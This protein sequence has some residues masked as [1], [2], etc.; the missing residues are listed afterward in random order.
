ML[1]GWR[2]WISI[3]ELSI[4]Q[5]KAKVD[6]GARTSCLHAFYLNTYRERGVLMLH[7]KVHPL[8]AN[9][10]IVVECHAEAIDRRMVTDSGGHKERRYVIYT[11]ICLGGHTWPI[12]ITLTNRD[13][14]RYRMLLGRTALREDILVAPSLSFQQGKTY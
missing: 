8:Q 14:M 11:P 6:T 10:K 5:V 2:E 4:N 9:K 12:E 1:L 7:F 3:P 13:I